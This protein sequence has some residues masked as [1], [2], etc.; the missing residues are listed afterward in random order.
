MARKQIKK[1]KKI[2]SSVKLHGR[3]SGYIIMISIIAVGVKTTLK[4]IDKIA[5]LDGH[6]HTYIC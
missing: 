1:N 2:K 5:Q 3:I 6:T 4:E